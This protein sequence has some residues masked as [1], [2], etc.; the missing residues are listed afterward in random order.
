MK[1]DDESMCRI[2]LFKKGTLSYRTILDEWGHGPEGTWLDV[3]T[4]A[5]LRE[6]DCCQFTDSDGTR[7]GAVATKVRPACI[8]GYY[9][10]RLLTD[11]IPLPAVPALTG[12]GEEIARRMSR[13]L[14]AEGCRSDD[15]NLDGFFMDMNEYLRSRPNCFDLVNSMQTDDPEGMIIVHCRMAESV[16]MGVVR[17]RMEEIWMGL[18]RYPE[19]EE[20]VIE[21]AEDGFTFHF[22]TWSPPELGV[23][24]RVLCRID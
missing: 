13:R 21:D 7:F 18:L 20:H 14:D 15:D 10:M 23:V 6:G 5:V 1:F 8:P 2:N 16:P 11:G 12:E 24:G 9:S 19:F 3:S 22:L 17:K 4:L